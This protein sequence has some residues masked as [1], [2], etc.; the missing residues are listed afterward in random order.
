MAT[1]KQ[2]E[3]NRP[4]NAQKSTG[5]RTE[6]GRNT[7]RLNAWKHGLTGHLNVMTDDAD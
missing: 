5:R 6:A 1:D 7:S 2:I 3:A 4:L